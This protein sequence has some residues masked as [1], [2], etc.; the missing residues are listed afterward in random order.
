L[1]EITGQDFTA[2]DFRTWAGTIL[3]AREL[4][5]AG[6]CLNERDGKKKIVAAVKN[7]AQRLGNRPATARKYYIHPAIIEAY[8]NG[9]LFETMRQGDAQDE[10]YG[11]YG[12]RP[13][14]YSVLVVVAEYQEKQVKQ[15]REV[16][17][18]SRRAA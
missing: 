15:T 8:S 1:R 4:T 16:M 11:G 7:V 12:L 9:T 5:A 10:A 3:G 14:E 13:E 6:P 18:G 2:K 17:R